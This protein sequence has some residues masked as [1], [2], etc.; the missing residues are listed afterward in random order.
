LVRIRPLA[1]PK[2]Q[3]H[4]QPK[5]SPWLGLISFVSGKVSIR[6][7]GKKTSR[8]FEHET[9]SVAVNWSTSDP[10]PLRRARRHRVLPVRAVMESRAAS[11]ETPATE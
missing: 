6:R 4:F 2:G 11:A 9:F 10:P 5:P 7:A 3:T 8:R 1:P